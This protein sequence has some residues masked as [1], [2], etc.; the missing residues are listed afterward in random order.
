MTRNVLTY[1]VALAACTL[2]ASSDLQAQCDSCGGSSISIGGKIGSRL[3]GGLL[4]RGGG[5]LGG[6]GGGAGY[7]QDGMTL[8]ATQFVGPRVTAKA[9]AKDFFTPHRVYA[10]SNNGLNAANTHVWNGNQQNVYSWHGG[11]QNWR[12]GTPTALVVPPTAG[13]QS[14]YAWGVGQTRSTP[15]HHQFGRGGAAMIGGGNGSSFQRTPY[16]P[17]STDQFGIYPVRSPW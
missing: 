1:M 5:I 4:Q 3:G 8:P 9:A 14:S 17:S 13:Y 10:Y 11:Y 12:W 7:D 6:G 16:W 2:M 15:I